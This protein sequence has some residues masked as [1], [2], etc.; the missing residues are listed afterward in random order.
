MCA[1]L[2]DFNLCSPVAK[3]LGRDL[4]VNSKF[5]K[6]FAERKNLVGNKKMLPN[7]QYCIGWSKRL[8]I[9]I[10]FRLEDVKI[11]F[12]LSLKINYTIGY[13]KVA[14]YVHFYINKR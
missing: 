12:S 9:C 5:C 6:D 14:I 8:N 3:L 13:C 7:A 1:K 10:R 2:S 11:F 4:H